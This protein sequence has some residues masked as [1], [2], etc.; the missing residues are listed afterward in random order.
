[1]GTVV[2]ATRIRADG[3]S[4]ALDAMTAFGDTDD[5]LV[6]LAYA[7]SPQLI[8]PDLSSHDGMWRYQDLLPIDDS[9][10]QYPL[11]VGG[12]PL[13]APP[14]LRRESGIA[15]LWLKDETRSP[16]GSNKDRATALVLEGAMRRGIGTVTAASTGNVAVSLAVGAAA[17][18]IEA[19]IFV[20]AEVREGKLR[21]MLLAGATVFRVQEGYEAAF[22]LSRAAARAFGWLDRNTGTN[23]WTVE[24]K[25]TVAFEIWEQL[26]R[27]LPDVVVVPVG[28]GTTLSAMAKG[29]RELVACGMTERLP[30]LIGVQAEGCQPLKHAW[31]GSK[32]TSI[33]AETIADGIAVMEGISACTALRDVRACHGAFVAVSD[34]QILE[35]IQTLGAH[36]G[37]I[38]EPA[39]ASGYAA[40]YG[41]LQAG[42]VKPDERIVILITG[43]GLKTPQYLQ[44]RGN[45]LHIRANL[46]EVAEAVRQN[47]KASED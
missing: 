35:A 38:A 16:T 8:P 18:G 42:F 30:R 32:N 37:L 6:E 43:S 11:P 28:D 23:P 25:K 13:V 12:T 47:V 7:Y 17:A 9:P 3:S 33:V 4:I 44:P 10:I 19:V 22:R 2:G 27:D 41:A 36:A 29:F 24:A 14:R 40:L 15:N 34:A 46:D 21:L 31:E 45:A 26:D 39:A 20:P 1:M 5:G